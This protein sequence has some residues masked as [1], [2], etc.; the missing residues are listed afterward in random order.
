VGA[1]AAELTDKRDKW[2]ARTNSPQ[3]GLNGERRQ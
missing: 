1:Q 2:A 3:Q